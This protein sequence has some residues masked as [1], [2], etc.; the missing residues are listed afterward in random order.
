MKLTFLAALAKPLPVPLLT[1]ANN[2]RLLLGLGLF[3]GGA[4]VFSIWK[5]RFLALKDDERASFLMFNLV[6]GSWLIAVFAVCGG[7][8]FLCDSILKFHA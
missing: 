7:I 1:N 3:I 5:D 4:L 8:Y 6:G 2:L